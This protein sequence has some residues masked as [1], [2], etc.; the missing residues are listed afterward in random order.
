MATSS[1][2]PNDVLLTHFINGLNDDIKEKLLTV[3]DET[4][5]SYEIREALEPHQQEIN[6]SSSNA[7]QVQI[8][9]SPVSLVQAQPPAPSMNDPTNLSVIHE[10]R[11]LTETEKQ[12]RRRRRA[13]LYCGK[14]GHIAKF[15]PVKQ[16]R[17]GNGQA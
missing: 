11:E 9:S 17:S 16:K 2:W 15:C 8:H 3:P 7:Q 6:K 14:D 12:D 4:L 1:G 10:H 5:E 13:C